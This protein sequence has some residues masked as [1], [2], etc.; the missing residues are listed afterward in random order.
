MMDFPA[1]Y[2]PSG[3]AE[4][5]VPPFGLLQEFAL[6]PTYSLACL[7]KAN[8]TILFFSKPGEYGPLKEAN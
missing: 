2:K 4:K 1:I 6:K 3:K 5:K 7:P 8:C